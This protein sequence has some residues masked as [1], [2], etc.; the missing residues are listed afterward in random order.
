MPHAHRFIDPHALAAKSGYLF[1]RLFV[2]SKLNQLFWRQEKVTH[3]QC[4]PSSYIPY[5]SQDT[6][7]KTPHKGG[8]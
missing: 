3:T 4:A 7:E 6:Q 2:T 1:R 8:V 5:G